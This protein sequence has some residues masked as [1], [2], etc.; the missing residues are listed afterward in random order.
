MICYSNPYIRTYAKN[1]SIE[2][3]TSVPE[4][5][6]I[7]PLGKK[8]KRLMTKAEVM[9]WFTQRIY[10][11]DAAEFQCAFQLDAKSVPMVIKQSSVKFEFRTA[12]SATL[13]HGMDQQ[14]TA[15]N[16]YAPQDPRA[17]VVLTPAQMHFRALRSPG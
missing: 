4:K 1:C 14:H 12:P 13:A 3:Q 16:M 10:A 2:V 15:M 5:D 9:W 17:W 11:M 6:F 7:V 8:Q